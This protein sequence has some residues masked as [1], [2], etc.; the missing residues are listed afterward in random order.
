VQ[1]REDFNDWRAPARPETK[2][3]I[4]TAVDAAMY[5]GLQSPIN[6]AV[7]IVD[8]ALGTKFLPQVEVVNSQQ[9]VEFSMTDPRWYAQQI[10]AGIGMAADIWLMTKMA[11]GSAL[12]S[13]G[14]ASLAAIKRSTTMGAVYSGLLTP[15]SDNDFFWSRT[16]NAL[17]GAATFGGLTATSVGL[18]AA[19]FAVESQAP[20][21]A[22][23]LRNPIAAGALSGI[24]AGAVAP[25]IHSL[26]E[27]KGLSNNQER[28][29]S[30]FTFSVLGAAIGGL[31]VAK[32]AI[33]RHSPAFD[34]K[35]WQMGAGIKQG[36]A[37]F[38]DS[39]S[40]QF[41]L[42]GAG[43]LRMSMAE[44]TRDPGSRM[45]MVDMSRAPGTNM[46]ALEGTRMQNGTSVESGNRASES[47][48]APGKSGTQPLEHVNY[49]IVDEPT[50][51]PENLPPSQIL[52]QALSTPKQ[53]SD[54]ESGSREPSATVDE[55]ATKEVESN[56]DIVDEPAEPEHPLVVL[57][58]AAYIDEALALSKQSIEA[59]KTGASGADELAQE[60][61]TKIGVSEYTSIADAIER[62]MPERAWHLRESTLKLEPGQEPHDK[63]IETISNA[64]GTD[65]SRLKSALEELVERNKE[66]DRTG[67]M[68]TVHRKLID[69]NTTEHGAVSEPVAQAKLA[70]SNYLAYHGDWAEAGAT[71]GE[72]AQIARTLYGDQSSQLADALLLQSKHLTDSRKYLEA[73]PILRETIA[74]RQANDASPTQ[75]ADAMNL[76]AKG[77]SNTHRRAEAEK[78]TLEAIDL[79]KDQP[80][81]RHTLRTAFDQLG[82][83]CLHEGRIKD[84]LQAY[85]DAQYIGF[86]GRF[87]GRASMLGYQGPERISDEITAT[88][89]P[90]TETM[91]AVKDV[92]EYNR[93]GV[94]GVLVRK[95]SWAIPNEEAL[96]TIRDLGPI[97]EIGAGSG[98]WS[99][100]LKARGADIKS[101][102]IAPLG[103][104]DGVKNYYHGAS[105]R[106]W[107]E[108]LPGDESTAALYPERTLMLSWPPYGEPVAYNALKNFKG[109][110]L[111][112]IGEGYSGCTGDDAFHELLEAEWEST[113]YVDI[114]QWDGI[115]DYLT[116]YKRKPKVD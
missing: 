78:V 15:S 4:E 93:Y 97:V 81:G 60:A 5:S 38:A 10:G 14:S 23:T 83:L 44:M 57:R 56:F 36:V 103:T 101:F 45:A 11:G 90:Y 96:T 54:L 13:E 37:S 94:R 111:V 18:R 100:M 98:Y 20:S 75:T 76:L 64:L 34:A 104:P 35:L 16:R 106:A 105:D 63:A 88:N 40:P 65:Q 50:G 46:P 70:Y 102:D 22:W 92:A 74:I 86:M 77:L 47:T 110:T 21:L 32:D 85:K 58:R 109:D 26:V 71:A 3:L 1:I 9:A 61:L 80:D 79:A 59:R 95:Y 66:G 43:G 31:D 30:A 6:G 33:D 42:S 49:D 29:Q 52:D 7:Q 51:T 19:S 72:A 113:K 67:Y 91:D 55:L 99:A 48:E 8:H 2:S 116:V 12:A 114:P 69:I 68:G 39:L 53:S 115:H 24:P 17:V 82:D 89:N 112:Y 108:I 87:R 107:T 62:Y 73:E 41:E 28:F 25:D 84:A 27:G